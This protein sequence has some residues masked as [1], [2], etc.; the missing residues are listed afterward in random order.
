MPK[1]PVVNAAEAIRALKRAD[2]LVDHQT[3]S[4]VTLI[5]RETKRRAV[6]PEHGG[7]DLRTGTLR[8]ILRDTGLS[9]EEFSRLLR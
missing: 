5:H 6:V 1:L 4:H 8:A 3:G 9:V 7:R 2:F